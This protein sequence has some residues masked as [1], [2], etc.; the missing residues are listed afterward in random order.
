LKLALAKKLKAA[1]TARR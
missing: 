1:R